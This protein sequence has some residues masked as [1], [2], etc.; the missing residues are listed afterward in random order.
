MTPGRIIVPATIALISSL[1]F[2]CRMERDSRVD[3]QNE[4]TWTLI[5]SVSAI[6]DPSEGATDNKVYFVSRL[7]GD[8]AVLQNRIVVN[9]ANGKHQFMWSSSSAIGGAWCEIEDL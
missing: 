1:G 6:L 9:G 5:R 2:G 4:S 3:F 7:S 8:D